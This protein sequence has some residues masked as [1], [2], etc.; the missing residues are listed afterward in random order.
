M[1]WRLMRP[2]T[3]PIQACTAVPHCGRRRPPLRHRVSAP[4]LLGRAV[5]GGLLSHRGELLPAALDLQPQPGRCRPPARPNRWP[6][7]TRAAP[8]PACQARIASLPSASR[9]SCSSK[10]SLPAVLMM[11][12][13]VEFGFLASAR[14]FASRSARRSLIRTAWPTERA[15]LSAMCWC[16]PRSSCFRS[17][18]RVIPHPRRCCSL[19]Y[20]SSSGTAPEVHGHRLAVRVGRLNESGSGLLV[21]LCGGRKTI[22]LVTRQARRC[23]NGDS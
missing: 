19:R 10:T 1:R 2:S 5:G 9:T 3:A 13:V 12:V 20:P 23:E 16:S 8:E 7:G 22:L 14:R 15:Y 18:P 4:L 17:A 6:C 11:S 21:S